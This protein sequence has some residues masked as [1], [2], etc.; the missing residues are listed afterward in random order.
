M[1]HPSFC[2]LWNAYSIYKI[3]SQTSERRHF[4]KLPLAS[5]NCDVGRKLQGL[6]EICLLSTTNL[7]LGKVEFHLCSKQCK[8]LQSS[9]RLL[10]IYICCYYMSILSI[11]Q[12]SYYPSIWIHPIDQYLLFS[13]LFFSFC[14]KWDC[15][16]YEVVKTLFGFKAVLGKRMEAII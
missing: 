8:D 1:K 14:V 2:Y 9:V 6:E 5:C 3:C 10:Y 12:S 7:H 15:S 11:H 13:D 16:K 4:Y